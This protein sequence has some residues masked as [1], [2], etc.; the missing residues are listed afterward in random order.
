MTN[1]TVIWNF[2]RTDIK[3]QNK[4]ETFFQVEAIFNRCK[5]RGVSNEGKKQMRTKFAYKCAKYS[6]L[7]GQLIAIHYCQNGRLRNYQSVN[8]AN[9]MNG[10]L[11][12]GWGNSQPHMRQYTESYRY[13]CDSM[14]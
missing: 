14:R 1:L 3:T 10:P 8:D 12:V 5:R 6:N 13:T 9:L 7:I 4:V 2:K 11:A